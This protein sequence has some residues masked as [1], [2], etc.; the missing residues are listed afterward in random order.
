MSWYLSAGLIPSP[1][2]LYIP[3]GSNGVPTKKWTHKEVML[4]WFLIVVDNGLKTEPEINIP[5][6]NVF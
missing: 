4:P 6:L 2:L 5:G 3:P 1:V